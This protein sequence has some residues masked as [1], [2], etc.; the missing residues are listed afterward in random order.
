MSLSQTVTVVLNGFRRQ[1]TLGEQIAALKSQSHPIQKIMYW[2]LKSNARRYQPDYKLL[3]KEDIE[4]AETSH[5]YG[6]WGR[7]SFALNANTAFVCIIDDDIMPGKDYIK[8]C[9]QCFQ[10][11]PGIYGAL[12]NA[13]NKSNNRKSLFGWKGRHNETVQQVNYLYQT[14]F[15][16]LQ[17]L[18]AFWS[19]PVPEKLSKNRHIA[20]D[21]HL[22]LM[23]KKQ[24]NLN[25][26]VVPH[27]AGNKRKWGNIT[28]HSHGLDA[29]AVHLNAELRNGMDM[30]LEYAFSQGL[31][32]AYI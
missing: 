26:Y 31:E 23:A 3:L 10:D 1:H 12:G 13:I 32:R 22:S 24:L 20:E 16:P 15:M 11:K 9:V 29:Y 25:T 28:G 8:N 27:P 6:V 17:A 2:N 19:R 7:F 14:W 5:D 21:I 30:Y 18:N 4:Y